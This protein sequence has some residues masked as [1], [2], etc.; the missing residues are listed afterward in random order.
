MDSLDVDGRL[1]EPLLSDSF[2]GPRP[3]REERAG[4]VSEY[5]SRVEDGTK[6][7]HPQAGWG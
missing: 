3:D 6:W 2:Q 1:P 5:C 7:L 4:G